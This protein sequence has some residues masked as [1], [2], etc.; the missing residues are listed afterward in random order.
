MAVTR[1]RHRAEI[2]T[3]IRAGDI[4]ESASAEGLEYLRRYLSY[5][6]EPG[7]PPRP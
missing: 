3:S 1:A 7:Q 5:A 2:V 4:P 6:A